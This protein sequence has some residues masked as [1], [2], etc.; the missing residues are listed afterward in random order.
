M[1]N[2]VNSTHK[3]KV[4][5]VISVKVDIIKRIGWFIRETSEEFVVSYIKITLSTRSIKYRDGVYR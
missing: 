2:D 5:N 4:K 3:K 1:R